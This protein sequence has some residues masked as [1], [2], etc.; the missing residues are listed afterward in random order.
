MRRGI[1]PPINVS[2]LLHVHAEQPFKHTFLAPSLDLSSLS[3]RRLAPPRAPLL[4]L[5]CTN[6]SASFLIF[7]NPPTFVAHLLAISKNLVQTT[8][9]YVAHLVG[10]PSQIESTM[11]LEVAEG[12]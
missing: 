3:R 4:E 7:C 12:W 9:E 10:F 2:L 11:L 1:I 8:V 5:F 6:T